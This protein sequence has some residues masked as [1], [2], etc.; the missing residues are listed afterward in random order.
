VT[1]TVYLPT[2]TVGT[3]NAAVPTVSKLPVA[4]DGSGVEPN[5]TINDVSPAG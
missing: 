3:Y 1:V 5:V 4:I 2:F